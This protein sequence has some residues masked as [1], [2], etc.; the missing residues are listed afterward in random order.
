MPP[1]AAILAPAPGAVVLAVARPPDFLALAWT[2]L[3]VGHAARA[4]GSARTLHCA[5]AL[6]SLIT[7]RVQATSVGWGCSPIS[8]RSRVRRQPRPSGPARSTGSRSSPSLAALS[9]G[10]LPDQLAAPFVAQFSSHSA[11]MADAT[12]RPYGA[13]VVEVF[14]V[15]RSSSFVPDLG[16]KPT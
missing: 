2:L 8:S 5:L 11:K 15:R 7:S 9:L 14:G 10:L 16:P 12:G 4:G 1:P 3:Q 6:G 13:Y